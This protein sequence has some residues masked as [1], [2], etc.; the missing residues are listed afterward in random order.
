MSEVTVV[1]RPNGKPY[2]ARKA[3]AV[4]TIEDYDREDVCVLVLR[5]HDLDVARRLAADEARRQGYE[6]EQ[7]GEACRSWYRLG[8]RDGDPFYEYDTTRGVP[9][10][11]YEID[12]A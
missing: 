4:L 2:R 5:T 1:E 12:I 11:V 7:L 6:Q 3:P 10:V 9:V 8:M